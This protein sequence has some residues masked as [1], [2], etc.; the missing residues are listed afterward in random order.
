MTQTLASTSLATAV[1]SVKPQDDG[2][3][4][5]R[6]CA[7]AYAART[8]SRNSFMSVRNVSD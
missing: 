3:T 4:R 7:Q 1:V 8:F 6:I 2:C 5:F